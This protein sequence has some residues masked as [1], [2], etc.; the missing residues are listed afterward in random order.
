[1]EQISCDMCGRSGRISANSK[2]LLE[3]EDWMIY[4]RDCAEK[5]GLS[6]REAKEQ[7][8]KV[9]QFGKKIVDN[10]Y[11]ADERREHE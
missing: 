9:Y 3:K 10:D 4:C 11:A 7:R 6:K 1:M 2:Y 8:I 5:I